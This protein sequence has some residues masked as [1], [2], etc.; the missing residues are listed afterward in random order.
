MR[1]GRFICRHSPTFS[2]HI[3]HNSYLWRILRRLSYLCPSTPSKISLPL[4]FICSFFGSRAHTPFPAFILFSLLCIGLR[5]I[6]VIIGSFSFWNGYQTA[7]AYGIIARR[8]PV[9]LSKWT[10]MMFVT[11]I[12]FKNAGG[13]L[14]SFGNQRMECLSSSSHQDGS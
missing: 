10:V 9:Y 5:R 13:P 3:Y 8:I 11:G 12:G 2:S 14:A 6:L 7:S 4:H 1:I